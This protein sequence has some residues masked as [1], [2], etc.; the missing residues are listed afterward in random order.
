MKQ[1]TGTKLRKLE[2][3]EKKFYKIGYWDKKSGR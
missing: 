2:N 1:I 3:E